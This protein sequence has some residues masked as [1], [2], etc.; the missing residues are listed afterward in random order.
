MTKAIHERGDVKLTQPMVQLSEVCFAN[1]VVDA[2]TVHSLKTIVSLFTNPHC[3]I[4][5]V[6]HALREKTN[7]TTDDY[8]TLSLNFSHVLNT[9][10]L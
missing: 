7:F 8:A 5:P 3:P 6:V 10:R 1:L 9:I 4:Q 2:G